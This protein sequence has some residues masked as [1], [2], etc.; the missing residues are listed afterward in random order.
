MQT[1]SISTAFSIS[2]PAKDLRASRL[3]NS[4]WLPRSKFTAISK[5]DRCLFVCDYSQIT[6]TTELVKQLGLSEPVC[7]DWNSIPKALNRHIR[8]RSRDTTYRSSPVFPEQAPGRPQGC[9]R[10][11]RLGTQSSATLSGHGGIPWKP[12]NDALDHPRS[13]LT[14]FYKKV[15][16]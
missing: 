12:I 16:L 5:F 13:H 14:T 6:Y 10:L 15:K 2:A 4:K 7:I 9:S 11:P 3:N 1:G 8:Y